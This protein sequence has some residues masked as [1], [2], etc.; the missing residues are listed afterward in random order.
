VSLIESLGNREKVLAVSRG[1]ND[2]IT[3]VQHLGMAAA[4]GRLDGHTP[5]SLARQRGVRGR[6]LDI[7]EKPVVLGVKAPVTPGSLVGRWSR[8]GVGRL[9]A[10]RQRFHYFVEERWLF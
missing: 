2:F 6:V 9:S 8:R 1:T 10:S 4:H 7:L 5:A 3:I